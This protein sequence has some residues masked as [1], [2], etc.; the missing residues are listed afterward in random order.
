MFELPGE[1]R[2]PDKA[3]RDLGIPGI[4][5]EELFD[6]HLSVQLPIAGQPDA[7]DPSRRMETGENIA[8][9]QASVAW[10]CI[11]WWRI[12]RTGRGRGRVPHA[13]YRHFRFD[14]RRL[15]TRFCG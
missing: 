15:V 3:G 6:G 13:Q 12:R 2:F 9:L 8:C 10:A 1:V 7:A 5:R 4:F 14:S 11:G